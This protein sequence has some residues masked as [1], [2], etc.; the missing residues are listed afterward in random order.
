M[1]MITQAAGKCC[2][3]D[4]CGNEDQR[5]KRREKKFP[6]IRESAYGLRMLSGRKKITKERSGLRREQLQTPGDLRP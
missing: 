4:D 2:P 6:T 5:R 1:T 3:C